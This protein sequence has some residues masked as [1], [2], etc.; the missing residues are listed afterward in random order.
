MTLNRVTSWLAGVG[1]CVLQT[2]SLGTEGEPLP[3][4]QLVSER[5]PHEIAKEANF[6][7]LRRALEE[8]VP[9]EPAIPTR[10]DK[11][12]M[13]ALAMT[14]DP[15]AVPV[16]I[17]ALAFNLNPLAP[18]REWLGIEAGIPAMGL[19]KKFFGEVALL[20]LY[21]EGIKAEQ[22]WYR[23]RI[24]YT[25]RLIGLCPEKTRK[26][27]GLESEA[28]HSSERRGYYT[29]PLVAPSNTLDR[30]NVQFAEQFHGTPLGKRFAILLSAEEIELELYYPR[31]EVDEELY[32]R[33]ERLKKAQRNIVPNPSDERP[34]ESP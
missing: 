30:M 3:F 23:T 5:D 8:A 4:E 11:T 9:N 13:Y 15:Q 20:R 2:I 28:V 26:Q 34:N 27:F 32:K 22:D 6:D 14:K 10:R 17:R 18:W 7:D 1:I 25:I 16:L 21:E 19:L 31:K 24:A 12:L 33:L 29:I